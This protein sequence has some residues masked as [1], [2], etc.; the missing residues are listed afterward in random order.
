V[1]EELVSK[2]GGKKWGEWEVEVGG[3]GAGG[4]WG[5][6]GGGGGEKYDDGSNAQPMAAAHTVAAATVE[7]H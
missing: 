6:G 3:E 7:A 2:E 5:G 1:V 4:G